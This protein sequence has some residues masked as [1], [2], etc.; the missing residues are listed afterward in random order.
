MRFK[1]FFAQSDPKTE[2][3]NFFETLVIIIIIYNYLLIDTTF[4]LRGFEFSFLKYSWSSDNDIACS[5]KDDWSN[6][7]TY[8]SSGVH[9]LL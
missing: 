3:D 6:I 5:D 7:T 1:I 2:A 8:K 9:Y 4:C